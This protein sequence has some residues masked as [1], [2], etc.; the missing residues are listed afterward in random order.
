MFNEKKKL[1]MYSFS[2]QMWIPVFYE[3]FRLIFN[4]SIYLLEI[5]HK[6]KYYF[7]LKLSRKV[8]K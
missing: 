4:G 7:L 8:P 6:C 2:L 5:V 1:A 3:T